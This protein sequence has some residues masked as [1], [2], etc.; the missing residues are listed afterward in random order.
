M[1]IL[2]SCFA[3]FSA[4]A[5]P[6]LA[7]DHQHAQGAHGGLG[8]VIF[9]NSGK[10]AAQPDFIRG[11]ALLHSFG[12]R[13]AAIAFRAAEKADPGFALAYW[14]EALTH[15]HPLWGQE[16]LAAARLAL[17][18]LGASSKARVARAKTP[19]ERAWGGAIEALFAE[20]KE[21]DRARAFADSMR[22]IADSDPADL[23]AS[24]F[25]AL[26]LLGL[27][28]QVGKGMTADDAIRYA[29]NVFAKNPKHPGAAH[30]LIHAFDNPV[31]AEQGL[32]F[33]R[34]YAKIAPDAEHALHMPSHIFLQIGAW[35]DVVAS[36][37]RA[38]AASRAWAKQNNLDNGVLDYH[39]LTW[40]QYA[41]LQQ[42]R[43]RDARA[44]I[45]T[46][47][48]LMASGPSNARYSLWDFWFQYASASG[49]WKSVSVADPLSVDEA[50]VAGA[51]FP[52]PD[53]VQAGVAAVSRGDSARAARIL[54]LL[55]ARRATAVPGS[56]SNNG[57][58]MG[59]ALIAGGIARLRGDQ[60]GAIA[61]YSAGAD[62]EAK[63]SPAGPPI[64]PPV[65]PAYGNLL[66]AN[67]MHSEA[68]RA[69][70][71]ELLLRKNHSASLLGLARAHRA[72]GN[73]AAAMQAYRQLLENWKRAD[74]DYPPL[75]EVKAGASS[76]PGI[77]LN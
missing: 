11:V 59:V 46:A 18:P 71:R 69:F 58:E 35:A 53:M 3:I 36:N 57:Y 54:S 43:F 39:S 72:Q 37:E 66:I 29:E 60:L 33:A 16:D 10:P 23:E 74:A 65:L 30:Y 70:E 48:T 50:P 1:R 44:L 68:V 4:L 47:R 9:P 55:K 75:R 45:D 76:S 61:F 12:Y 64:I 40:L 67:R 2:G 42:G 41:Y 73:P 63:G 56:Y 7:Q 14:M 27:G 49:D 28:A 22:R 6:A 19:R 38:W 51:A 32:P 17:S 15:R 5:A 52:L 31:R 8:T 20:G 77:I 24:A 13:D 62:I 25:A 21:V 26:G 34:E